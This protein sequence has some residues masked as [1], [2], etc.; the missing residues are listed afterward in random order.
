M[1]HRIILSCNMDELTPIQNSDTTKLTILQD[2]LPRRINFDLPLPGENLFLA[3]KRF[4][5]DPFP[6]FAV[7]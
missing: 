6:K 3:K 1:I 4:S 5:P 2:H 7:E